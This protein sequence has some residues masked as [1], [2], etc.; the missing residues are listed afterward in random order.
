MH[1]G[2][3]TAG[4]RARHERQWATYGERHRLRLRG[5]TASGSFTWTVTGGIANTPPV[6]N[7]Q[8]VATA[9]DATT[10]ITLTGSD[11]EGDSL[12]FSVQVRARHGTLS[13]VAPNLTYTPA[14]NYNGA[15]SFNLRRL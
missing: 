6:A 8:S 3:T 10:G 4:Q 12:T 7:P 13:G 2:F 14:A 15:D 11:A 9:E 1:L 5:N